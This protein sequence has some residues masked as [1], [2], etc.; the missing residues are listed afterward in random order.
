MS[1]PTRALGKNGPQVTAIGFGFMGLSSFYGDVPSDEDRLKLIDHIYESGQRF[2]DTAEMYGDSEEL[3]GKWFKQN[4]EKRKNV[5][6]ATKFGYLPEADG[7]FRAHNEPE[8]IKRAFDGSL[9]KLNTDYI[10]LYYVHRVDPNIAIE[11]T[12]RELQKLKA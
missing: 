10:D 9:K 2:W 3:I 7:S 12:V 6:L 5:F 8:D 1:V 11:L 4:P